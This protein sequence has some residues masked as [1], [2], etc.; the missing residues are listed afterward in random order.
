VFTA[1]L[2]H[3]RYL[4]LRSDG[5]SPDT[6][7]ADSPNCHKYRGLLQP[8]PEREAIERQ[9]KQI[10]N[11]DRVTQRSDLVELAEIIL[12]ED[13]D[14]IR[15]WL[16]DILPVVDWIRPHYVGIGNDWGGTRIVAVCDID[17]PH[18]RASVGLVVG[19]D[20]TRLT[21]GHIDYADAAEFCR[22]PA[23]PPPASGSMSGHRRIPEIE[24]KA[25]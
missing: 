10:F 16:N 8:D 23:L 21:L 19:I 15:H 5:E 2:Q 22:D 11:P 17:H 1:C 3:C 13:H 14:A 18:L 24:K 20:Q 25:I 9:L 12:T 4:N 6:C 7:P